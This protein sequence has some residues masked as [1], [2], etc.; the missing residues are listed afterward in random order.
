LKKLF[1]ILLLIPVLG[2]TQTKT[3]SLEFKIKNASTDS[4]KIHLLLN[5][6][7]VLRYSDPSNSSKLASRALDIAEKNNN[8]T[9]MTMA[10]NTMGFIH[11]MS[12]KHQLALA[13]FK[14][15]LKI[16]QDIG[17]SGQTAI[18]YNNL[19]NYYNYRGLNDRALEHYLLSLKLK[20]TFGDQRGIA[21]NV[22]NI[23]LIYD[24]QGK[25]NQALESY[26]KAL[27]IKH[28]LNDER[29][30]ALVSTNIGSMYLDYEQFEK[31]LEYLS[32][33]LNINRQ[34]NDL[35]GIA[36]CLHPVA[37]IEH[38]KGNT[39]K[40]F[41]LLSEA[42]TIHLE[43]KNP[44]GLQ[45]THYILADIYLD[46]KDTRK[47]LVNAQASIQYAVTA[48]DMAAEVDAWL[49]ISII[50]EADNNPKKALEAHRNATSLQD[51]LSEL[52]NRQ[53]IEKLQV[54]YEAELKDRKLLLQEQDIAILN[55]DKKLKLYLIIG[56]LLIVLLTSV[57]FY[58]RYKRLTAI[59]QF[60]KKEVNVKNKELLSFTLQTAQ[61]NELIQQLKE[62]I[63]LT[64]DNIEGNTKIPTNKIGNMFRSLQNTEKDWEEFRLRFEQVDQN[65]IQQLQADFPNLT[66]TDVRICTLI[67]LNLSAKEVSSML[68]ITQESVNTS[69]YRLRK[70]LGLAK[71]QDLN[72]FI[73]SI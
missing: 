35:R 25:F 7:N 11:L 73:N 23:G 67:R 14:R 16:N 69:R 13:E 30:V 3:D 46:Q 21:V 15:G 42:K 53:Y 70:K 54:E 38:H 19:G 58:S 47:A 27:S 1:I 61:K 50:R 9:Q 22:T 57:I 43:L 56:L 60:L 24:D 36:D 10:L 66:S 37:R 34:L 48:G 8:A 6:A 68:N 33:A 5:Q 32:K 45:Q 29:G 18:A 31:A 51:S 63:T 44:T 12:G 28:S 64:V 20:E 55:Q 40:A 41:E 49:Q 52:E 4:I 26:E 17:D 2:I 39:V 59:K 72:Q 62:D 65:F 71:E